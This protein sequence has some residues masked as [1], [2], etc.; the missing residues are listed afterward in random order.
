LEEGRVI[1]AVTGA[2]APHRHLPRVSDFLVGG[3]VAKEFAQVALLGGEE[4][5]ADLTVGGEAGAVTVAAE[6]PGHAADDADT[7]GL[8]GDVGVARDEPRLGRG[9]ST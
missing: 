2:F 9:C 7:G 6:R 4:A 8:A 1:D 3:S 5:V